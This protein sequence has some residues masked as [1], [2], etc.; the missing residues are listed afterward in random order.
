MVSKEG[1]KCI[2]IAVA[3]FL[4]IIIGLIAGSFESVAVLKFGML[5]DSAK[6]Q[7]INT[8]SYLY[9][10]GRYAAG[11]GNNFVELPSKRI[12]LALS[13]D[14]TL[15]RA[16]DYSESA[17]TA[18]TNEGIPLIC[19]ISCQIRLIDDKSINNKSETVKKAYNKTFL[20]TLRLLNFYDGGAVYKAILLTILKSTLLDVLSTYQLNDVY[21]RRLVMVF[22][23]II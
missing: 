20:K 7:I 18:R 17:I 16:S 5:I 22:F 8:E 2:V 6:I 11:L 1:V 3:V 15:K 13:D 14:E 23:I 21:S 4:A 19:T 12:T 9:L 10:S